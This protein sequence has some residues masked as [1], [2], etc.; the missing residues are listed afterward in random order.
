MNYVIRNAKIE[1]MQGVMKAHKLSIE[2]LC[3]KDYSP[4]QISCWADVKYSTEIWESSVRD[5]LHHVV[6]V[7]GKIE[8]FCH[9]KVLTKGEGVVKGL[10]F[11]PKVKD[12]GIG[13]EIFDLAM[14]NFRKNNCTKLFISATKTARGFYERMGFHVVEE[15]VLNVRG[16]DLEC[17]KMERVLK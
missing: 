12:L 5:D 16:A 4:D 10:Y 9:S 13:K 14:E 3:S 11:T 17:Y 6:E 7:D 2:Q 1:D 8:G 15:Y